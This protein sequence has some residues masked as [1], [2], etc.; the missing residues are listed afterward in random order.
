MKILDQL[1]NIGEH[2]KEYLE[3]E[4]E[5]L[6]LKAVKAISANAAKLIT[7]IFLIMLFHIGLAIFGIWLGVYLGEVLDSYAMGFGISALFF[8]FLFLLVIIFRRPL[9]INPITNMAIHNMV[10]E[11][12]IPDDHEKRA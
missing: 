12:K 10:K 3:G 2:F 5:L 7:A 11:K 6:K 1:K 9:L 8:G 4:K